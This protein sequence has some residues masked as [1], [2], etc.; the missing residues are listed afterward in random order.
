MTREWERWRKNVVNMYWNIFVLKLVRS[1]KIITVLVSATGHVFIAGICNYLCLLC[2]LYF[3]FP[4]PLRCTSAGRVPQ[5]LSLKVLGVLPVLP[6]YT[7]L[8]TCSI[9]FNCR[10]WSAMRCLG[11]SH[12]FQ[13]NSSLSPIYCGNLVSSGSV[14][15]SVTT[16]TA[17]STRRSSE[18]S[19]SVSNARFSKACPLVEVSFLRN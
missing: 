6:A 13:M 7:E 5:S 15:V 17:F 4:L 11:G 16:A 3:V 9:D 14:T 2:V 12:K 19:A 8:L 18:W 10:T 1:P